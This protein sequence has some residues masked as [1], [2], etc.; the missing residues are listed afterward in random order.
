NNQIKTLEKERDD[1]ISEKTAAKILL[2]ETESKLNIAYT[3]Q[4]RQE[5]NNK[6][7]NNLKK[8]LDLCNDV[9]KYVEELK[10]VI[11]NNIRKN[12]EK[13]TS[14]QFKQLMWKNNFEKVL[15]SKNYDVSLVEVTG[16]ISSTG[17]LSAGEKLVLALSFVAALNNISTFKLPIIIDT[18]MGRLGP[19]MINNISKTFPK[20]MANKQ[21][22]LLVTDTEY[23]EDF[24]NGIK[25]KVF[26]EYRIQHD[27]GNNGSK[28]WV[29]L[30]E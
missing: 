7:V 26:Y 20:Y 27:E 17:T 2:N 14:E 18:P 19:E 11:D 23:N 1:K 25:E 10:D 28:S 21:V 13:A 3:N 15:I 22:T 5:S 9:I 12:V 8:Q 24:K 16:D 6:K 29:V 30:N 4:K